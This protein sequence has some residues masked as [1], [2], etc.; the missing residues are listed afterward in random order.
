MNNY[1]AQLNYN[2]IKGIIFLVFD[3]L[4]VARKCDDGSCASCCANTCHPSR[5]VCY[6]SSEAL[7]ICK[8]KRKDLTFGMKTIA[9]KALESPKKGLVSEFLF[10]GSIAGNLLLATSGGIFK[11]EVGLNEWNQVTSFESDLNGY[12]NGCVFRNSLLVV[13]SNDSLSPHVSFLKPYDQ[14]LRLKPPI[15]DKGIRKCLQGTS[16][17]IEPNEFCHQIFCHTPIPTTLCFCS[18][19]GMDDNRILV[20]GG[21]PHSNDMKAFIGELNSRQNDLIWTDVN[22]YI[23]K[24]RV[25]PMIFKMGDNIYIAGGEAY[26]SP[27]DTLASRCTKLR[28][29]IS[30]NL[31]EKSWELCAYTLPYPLSHASVFVSPDE[32]FAMITGGLRGESFQQVLQEPFRW[33]RLGKPSKEIILFTK[34]KGF[35]IFEEANLIKSRFSHTMIPITF[36]NSQ[37]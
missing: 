27:N 10:G 17:F 7:R 37:R 33:E 34:E 6:D 12:V 14:Q 26:I 28:T 2:F 22:N 30:F 23:A 18:V 20:V 13:S 35:S 31:K 25:S 16:L 11:Y 9:K 8:Y 24:P 4:I 21:H 15:V 3:V 36:S 1:F 29:C 19:T 32:T 5:R